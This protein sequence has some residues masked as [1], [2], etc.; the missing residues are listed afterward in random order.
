MTRTGKRQKAAAWPQ[1]VEDWAKLLLNELA[2]KAMT[3]DD[4]EIS[5]D[6]TFDQGQK[7]LLATID[8]L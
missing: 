5:I 8:L 4:A 6:D 1:R 7:Y 3:E 2:Q